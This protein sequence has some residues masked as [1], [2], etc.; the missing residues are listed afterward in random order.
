MYLRQISDIE[1]RLQD[2]LKE[3][4]KARKDCKEGINNAKS[5]CEKE[6]KRIQEAAG[7]TAG[8]TGKNVVGGAFGRRR[9]QIRNGT[10]LNINTKFILLRL[11]ER[12]DESTKRAYRL[13][14]G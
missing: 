14:E 5:A 9:R 4:N 3:V 1:N 2:C 6:F 8:D 12:Q 11:L 7:G 13:I 10:E